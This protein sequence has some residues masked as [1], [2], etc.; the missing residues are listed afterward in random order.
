MIPSVT[1]IYVAP[2]RVCQV[3]L[4]GDKTF[5][6]KQQKYKVSEQLKTGEATTLFGVF[7]SLR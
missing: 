5:T 3:D 7:I 2:S 1:P 6:L 4:K